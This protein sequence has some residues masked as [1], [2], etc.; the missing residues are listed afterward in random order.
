MSLGITCIFFVLEI[1]TVL[2][3]RYEQIKTEAQ[4][5]VPSFLDKCVSCTAKK[6][7]TFLLKLFILSSKCSHQR[8]F[9]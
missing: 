9:L 7:D 3:P 5:D 8:G 4:R 1:K 6:I 2:E